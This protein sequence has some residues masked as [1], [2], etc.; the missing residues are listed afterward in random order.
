MVA[1]A[2]ISGTAWLA[3]DYLDV[4]AMSSA[5]VYSTPAVRLDPEPPTRPDRRS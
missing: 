5:R 4:L 3:L 1:L 2:A